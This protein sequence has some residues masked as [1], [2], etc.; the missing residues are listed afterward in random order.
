MVNQLKNFTLNDVALGLWGL[1][2]LLGI[3]W[4][5]SFYAVSLSLNDFKPMQI[6]ACR[7]I[8]GALLLTIVYFSFDYSSLSFSKVNKKTWFYSFGMG[9]FTNALPFFLLSWAQ[10]EVSS[11]FA[12]VAMSVVPFSTLILAH[13]FT[14]EKTFSSEKIIG[15]AIGFVGMIILFDINE[16]YNQWVGFE[17][18]KFKVACLGA[19]ISYSIGAIITRRSPTQS[20]LAFS[21]SG[22]LAGA[23]VILPVALFC[24]G[25]PTAFTLPS[26]FAIVYLGV[27]P[28]GLAT[29]ILVYL[30]KSVGPTFL[31]LVNYLV[32]VWAILFGVYLNSELLEFKF[33]VATA[34]I[35]YGM[36]LSQRV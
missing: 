13:Y 4:G 32:P 22:L 11:S 24:E 14:S 15:L 33:F 21:V 34:F 16:I 1:L 35:F 28:T 18:F 19:A 36:I 27:F 31:S 10:T 6:A 12:G 2:F 26:F 8:I 9:V 7:I 29:I 20:K 23:I 5:S 3:I 30:I 25:V 17:E